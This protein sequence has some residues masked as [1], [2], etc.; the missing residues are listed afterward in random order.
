MIVLKRNSRLGRAHVDRT[1]TTR[2]GNRHAEPKSATD[3]ADKVTRF[4]VGQVV[5]IAIGKHAGRCGPICY[6][7]G[8]KFGGVRVGVRIG[9]DAV[10]VDQSE[11]D[12][13][14]KPPR[15]K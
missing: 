6:V 10:F 11:I 9:D 5:K 2:V 14:W 12:V 7:G 1:G 13:G 3:T 15:R 4:K 8:G